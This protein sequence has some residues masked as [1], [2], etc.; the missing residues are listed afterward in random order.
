M[1]KGF[2]ILTVIVV[3]WFY[4]IVKIHPTEHLRSMPPN[5]IYIPKLKK[6][7]QS[8]ILK[9]PN[10]RKADTIILI[11]ANLTVKYKDPMFLALE[12]N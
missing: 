12:K 9:D 6:R 4:A 5:F 8:V 7:L 10:K 2:Y 3:K 1:T 11:K